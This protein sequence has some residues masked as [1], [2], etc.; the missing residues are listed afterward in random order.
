M[1]NH[2]VGEAVL[3]WLN[4]DD[5]ESE[6]KSDPVPSREYVYIMGNP[7]ASSGVRF[8]VGRSNNLDRRHNDFAAAF[9][10]VQVMYC[11]KVSDVVQAEAAAHK[12]LEKEFRRTREWFYGS[13]EKIKDIV[14]KSIELYCVE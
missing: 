13:F 10:E 8:K 9:P 3:K 5:A 2:K 14:E 1:V 12:A 11:A 6:V 4:S 7:E